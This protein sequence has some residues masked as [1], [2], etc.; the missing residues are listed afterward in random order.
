M[1]CHLHLQHE[2]RL[3]FVVPSLLV[4]ISQF[5][6][7]MKN[8]VLP[9]STAVETRRIIQH[10]PTWRERE[11]KCISSSAM[12]SFLCVVVATKTPSFVWPHCC[13]YEFSFLSSL[14]ILIFWDSRTTKAVLGLWKE[15]YHLL[16]LHP[17][18]CIRQSRDTFFEP[19]TFLPS[20]IH[21]YIA[22]LRFFCLFFRPVPS[23]ISLSPK[24]KGSGAIRK[25]A[26]DQKQARSPYS[27]TH[28]SYG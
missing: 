10:F 12:Q 17:I 26:D 6:C 11:R 20:Y 8:K 13:V 15:I 9:L 28:I 16:L 25:E 24:D 22:L 27:I 1:F 14:H 4:G 18:E 19:P 23:V 2:S 21:T 7:T 3:C 5:T